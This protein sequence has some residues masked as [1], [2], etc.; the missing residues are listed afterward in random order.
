MALRDDIIREARAR[1][2]IPYGLPPGPGETDC[3][4][5]V[6][7][8]FEAAGVPFPAGVR[9]AE[10]ERQASVPIGWGDVLPGDLLF[11]EGTYDAGPPSAD[12]HIASHIGISLG[13]GTHRMLN[14][15]EPVSAETRIDTPYWQSHIFEARRHPALTDAVGAT[16]EQPWGV[17]VA[18]HQGAV[19]WHA[20]A[21]DGAS[22]GFT[23]ATGGSWYRN[24]TFAAN[25]L[26]MQ[27]AGLVRGAYHFAF[28]TSGQAFP[29]DGPEDEAEYFVAELRRAGGVVAGDLL[30]LDI[31]DGEGALG[32]WCVR[33]LARVE[34]LTGVRPF[35]Y[36]GAWFSG[37][38]G[39]GKTPALATYPLWLAAYQTTPPSPPPPWS[40]V[41]IWQHAADGRVSGI[42][43]A[44]DMNISTVS[45]D[46]LRALGKPG[47]G[48]GT[49]P[50]STFSVGQGILQ[51][52]TE[53]GDA[54]ASD[55]LQFQ[56]GAKDEWAEAMG[57]SGALYRYVTSLN[58]TF[59][60]PPA[61]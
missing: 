60:F 52:M 40:A 35:I 16:D 37:P 6:R 50:A 48:G 22:F 21:G 26:G 10:Q 30:A 28:E 13:A 41:T 23:K 32:D 4:L 15:L 34:S 43:G 12:G 42:S 18:S 44:V 14:A 7:D 46:Q 57:V 8:V 33:W 20:V 58:K 47:T 29:G 17:D 19:D 9:V 55:E 31:E 38:H 51:T 39:L 1:L 54:P 3:S 45:L 5:Y 27:S 53:A 24:P 36:T 25:W 2:G 49:V 61:A 11:F 59:R 56:K